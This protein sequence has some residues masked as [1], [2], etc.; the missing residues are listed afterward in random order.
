MAC[1]SVAE[2]EDGAVSEFDANEF[3]SEIQCELINRGIMPPEW[4]CDQYDTAVLSA[5]QMIA[6]LIDERDKADAKAQELEDA[7]VNLE[8]ADGDIE[9]LND[10]RKALR[11]ELE[12]VKLAGDGL[13]NIA[14]NLA[15]DESIPP[16][17]R[18]AF[19]KGYEE[20]D[21]AIKGE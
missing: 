9:F 15:Q 17:F 18:E 7:A 5:A 4:P 12:A 11:A 19:K 14:Y 3:L 20:W 6:D 21:R 1:I 2:S 8:A 13:S 16:R 10:D